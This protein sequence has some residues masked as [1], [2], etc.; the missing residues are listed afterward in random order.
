MPKPRK[1]SKSNPLEQRM[2]VHGVTT[3]QANDLFSNSGAR[4]GFGTPSLG[5]GAEYT[6]VRLSFDYWNLITLFRNHWISRRIVETPAQDYVKAWPKLTS[7][8]EPKD[9]TRIDRALRKT[10]TKQNILTGLT[11][12]RL[13]GGAGGLMVIDGQEDELDQPLDLE[14]I[15]IGAYKGLVPFDMWAGI[16]PRGDVCTDIN[17]PLDFGKPEMYDVTPTGGSSFQVHS[18][19]VLRFLGPTVPSPEREA[20]SWWGISVLE[21]A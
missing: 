2:G 17:R 16:H 4:M 13:F 19:R 9:L 20:Q 6:L 18:S 10:N 12:G 1:R 21:P 14:S 5:Q 15:K 3:A 8:I 7:E 11:W